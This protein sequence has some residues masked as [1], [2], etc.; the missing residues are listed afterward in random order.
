MLDENLSR[1]IVPMLE[2]DF[3]GSTHVVLVG[4]G[5]ASDHEIWSYAKRENFVIVT[6]DSDFSDGSPSTALPQRLYGSAEAT[7]AGRRWWRHC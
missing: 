5:Q 2:R 4:L 1:R 7:T 3:P 6:R